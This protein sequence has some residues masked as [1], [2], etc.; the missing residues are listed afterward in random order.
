MS[1]EEAERNVD[2]QR[3]T[4]RERQTD[5]D[6]Q[7]H[8]HT[9]RERERTHSLESTCRA[10]DALGLR[11][12]FSLLQIKGLNFKC[13]LVP[14]TPLTH[15]KKTRT[16]THTHT[17]T[18]MTLLCFFLCFWGLSFAVVS[19]CRRVGLSSEEEAS[20][21]VRS[22]NAVRCKETTVCVASQNPKRKAH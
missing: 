13:F 15:T 12:S 8:G 6:T 10:G 9:D 20:A 5:T 14:P 3:E 19:E 18:Q 1:K 21:K 17:H 4:G 2:R 22:S 11:A 16:H 7:T